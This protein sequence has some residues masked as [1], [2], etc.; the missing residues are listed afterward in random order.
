MAW[1]R[2]T[3]Q[4]GQD[5][6]P[7]DPD[8]PIESTDTVGNPIIERRR[9]RHVADAVAEEPS[10]LPSRAEHRMLQLVAEGRVARTA[11]G[12]AAA[13]FWRVDGA[14]ATG[15]KSMMLDWLHEQGYIAD[16]RRG[17]V[18]VDAVLT[19]AGLAVLDRKSTRLNSS[20]SG[21]SRMPSS[22]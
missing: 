16:G 22:A 13:A 17:R 1:F 4:P 6:Q 9:G 2:R 10:A 11:T 15:T 20:H 19:D 14:F 7:A 12:G 18:A 21:E 5:E 8:G 3:K